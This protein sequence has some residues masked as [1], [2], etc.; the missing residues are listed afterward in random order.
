MRSWQIF[1]FWGIPF[2]VHTNWLILLFLFSWSVSNQI[3]ITSSEIYNYEESWIIG[4]L[5]SLF[6]LGSIILHQI[7][8]TFVSLREG[9]K[10]KKITFFFL[11]AILETEKD[12]NTA[13]GNIKISLIRPALSL[14]TAFILLSIGNSIDSKE[15]LSTDIIA[16]VALL[17]IFLSFLNLMPFGPLDG[18]V[19]LK[20]IVWHYS[21]NKKKGRVF[22]NKISLITSIFALLFGLLLLL[23]GV[24]YY[25]F[26]LMILALFGINNSKSESQF[27]KIESILK[28]NNISDIKLKSLRKIEFDL[29]FKEFNKFVS[30]FK[31][32][33]DDYFFITKDGRWEG[34]ISISNLKDVA[35][36]KWGYTTVSEFKKPINKFPSVMEGTPLW[37]I[38][39][40]IEIT[41]DGNLLVLNS[42]GIPKGLIDRNAVGYFILKKL[43]LNIS[44]ELIEKIKSHNKYPL[45]IELPKIIEL[46]KNKGDI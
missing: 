44:F 35:I 42:L 21:G 40:M 14:F 37:K 27:L 41:N 25:G 1:K 15:T 8:H 22:L 39:E 34:F 36:N 30:N 19:L 24:F 38:I 6:F 2:K 11:G 3:N 26:I 33:S 7:I 9:V 31:D 29:T 32:Q 46:M 23:N 45:G 17:N 12:C 43:G 28:Q 18:G 5:T 10:F 13:L 4:F 20:S 16:R